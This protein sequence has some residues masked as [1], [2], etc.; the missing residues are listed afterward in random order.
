MLVKKRLRDINET[1][2]MMMPTGSYAKDSMKV[3]DT[4]K[5]HTVWLLRYAPY[6]LIQPAVRGIN[7]MST[8]ASGVSGSPKASATAG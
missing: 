3:A 1:W 4:T 8:S 6:D 5:A 2:N 7:H